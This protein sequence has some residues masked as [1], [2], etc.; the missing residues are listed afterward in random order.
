MTMLWIKMYFYVHMLG[1]LSEI[2][3][4]TW[5]AVEVVKEVNSYAKQYN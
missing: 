3:I 2:E 4:M 1:K 5:Q